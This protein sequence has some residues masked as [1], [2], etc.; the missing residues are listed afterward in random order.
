MHLKLG[1]KG[2]ISLGMVKVPQTLLRPEKLFPPQVVFSVE[3]ANL[4]PQLPSSWWLGYSKERET[5][6]CQQRGNPGP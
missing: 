1:Q 5:Q 2:K 6:F 4:A 3:E